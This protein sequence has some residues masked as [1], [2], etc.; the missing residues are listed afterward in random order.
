MEQGSL[1]NLK[2]DGIYIVAMVQKTYF[3]TKGNYIFLYMGK[4]S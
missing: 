2:V 3:S 1:R 4:I